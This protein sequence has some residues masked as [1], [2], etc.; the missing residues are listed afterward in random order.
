M[1]CWFYNPKRNTEYFFLKKKIKFEYESYIWQSIYAPFFVAW[2]T[3]LHQLYLLLSDNVFEQSYVD[4]CGDSDLLLV[5]ELL[6]WNA[7]LWIWHGRL[8]WGL[9][10]TY[11]N[12]IL[13][14]NTPPKSQSTLTDFV[15]NSTTN[16]V[17]YNT[18]IH[19]VPIFSIANKQIFASGCK[20]KFFKITISEFNTKT[21]PIVLLAFKADTCFKSCFIYFD[22]F[23]YWASFL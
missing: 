16:E 6:A 3:S 19:T 10:P 11:E 8:L 23:L 13:W 12:K 22:V 21:K 14:K 15:Y 1:L 4:Q 7:T 5:S 9:S 20:P 18:A 17:C 2:T